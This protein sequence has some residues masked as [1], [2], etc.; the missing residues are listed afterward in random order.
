MLL[1][2]DVRRFAKG[3]ALPVGRGSYSVDITSYRAGVL[4]DPA[5]MY[6]EVQLLDRD[7]SV[8]RTLPHTDFVFR[9]SRSGDGLRTV[10]FINGASQREHFLLI[11]NRP[12]AE[13]DL[14]VS[15]SNITSAVPVTIV[16]PGAVVTWMVPTGSNTAPVKM[17]ASPIGELVVTLQEYRPKK[18]GE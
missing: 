10:F 2:G 8:I 14:T 1:V 15:Q 17:K 3:F 5:I 16:V 18:I 11:T 7:Y 12:M 6:P 9:P 4:S 13:A